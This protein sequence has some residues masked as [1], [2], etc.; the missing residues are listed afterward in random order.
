MSMG[1]VIY[2][3]HV[4]VMTAFYSDLLGASQGASGEGGEWAEL[5]I[6]GDRLWIHLAGSEWRGERDGSTPVEFR[7]QNP[8]KLVFSLPAES[9]IEA[10]VRELG[11][12]VI[13]RPWG[14][15]FC[16]PEGNVFS[17][18]SGTSG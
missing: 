17:V 3:R 11:G 16:D 8:V 5:D 10:R 6:D 4:G 12:F 7:E 2:V 1:A 13:E 9:V 18:Q 14:I 15:D